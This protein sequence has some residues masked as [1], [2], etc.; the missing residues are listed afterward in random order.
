MVYPHSIEVTM[1]PRLAD[2]RKGHFYSRMRSPEHTGQLR[3]ATVRD[4]QDVASWITTARECELW[5][6]P[7][8]RFPLDAARLPVLIDF[9]HA[10]TFALMA[11]DR[12]AA[13]GQIIPKAAGRGHLARVI[14]APELRG[15]GHGE[16]LIRL[17]IDEARRQSHVRISLNVDR[18]NVPAIALYSK[19]GFRETARPADEPDAF[20]SRYMERE[21]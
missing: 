10:S 17:L 15:Q 20:G 9:A 19:L 14:V 18:Q 7:R 8:L 4:L 2:S 3:R 13:F 16:R 5:A 11:G 1:S 6:G 12:L 21:A